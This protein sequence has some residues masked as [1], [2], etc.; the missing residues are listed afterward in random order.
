MITISSKKLSIA[1]RL[2]QIENIHLK[3]QIDNEEIS[4]RERMLTPF[5][6]SISV[7]LLKIAPRQKIASINKKLESAGFL[8]NYN[9]QKWIFSKIMISLLCSI[10]IAVFSLSVD[11]HIFKALLLSVIVFITVN[12]FFNFYLTK[13]I[14]SRKKLILRDLPYT[15]DLI[16]V[17]VEAGLSFDGAMT[18]VINNIDGELCNEFAKGLKEIKM[19]IDRKT[20]LNNMSKRCDV[21]ELSM[22]VT[23]LIQADNLGVSLGRVL[24]IES[25]NL[26][27]QR[28]QSAREKAMKAPIKML[29]P[30][31]FF[32]FPSIFII[33]LGPAVIRIMDIFV[34]R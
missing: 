4:F 34:K 16:T 1:N 5:Y 30:L 8:K 24:R 31:I 9:A 2:K 10:L 6:N 12:T 23:A 14:E 29:F 17:S 28:K 32:I 13:R 7:F 20:A 26:R 27:E 21:K 11:S 22:F 19:G 3:N 15:L 18:R 33:I 25:S